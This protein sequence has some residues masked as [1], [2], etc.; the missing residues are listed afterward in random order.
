MKHVPDLSAGWI[1]WLSAEWYGRSPTRCSC[2]E[3]E[4]A[5]QVIP[6]TVS[7]A[8]PATTIQDVGLPIRYDIL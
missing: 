7:L 1:P 2:T 8:R 3:N 5:S 4:G 6:D